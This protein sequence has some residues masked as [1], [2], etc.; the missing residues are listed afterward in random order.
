MVVLLVGVGCDRMELTKVNKSKE[1]GG[2][3]CVHLKLFAM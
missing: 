1:F 3:W 2:S